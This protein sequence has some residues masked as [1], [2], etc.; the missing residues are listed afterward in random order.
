MKKSEILP[1][2]RSLILQDSNFDSFEIQIFSGD[3]ENKTIQTWI[4]SFNM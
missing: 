3:D 4:W 2:L 1:I